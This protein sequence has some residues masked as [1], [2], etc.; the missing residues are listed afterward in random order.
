[1]AS[2]G[3]QDYTNF[4]AVNLRGSTVL[5]LQGSGGSGTFLV[6]HLE[7]DRAWSFPDKSGRFAVAGTF[8]VQLPSATAVFF[9]TIVTVTGIRAEDGLVVINNNPAAYQ[10]GTTAYILQG[11]TPGAG[12]VTLWFHNLGNATAYVEKV[13]SY[14]AVR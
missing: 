1:M 11:A 5:R 3:G 2:I 10:T 7:A 9:S 4:R 8:T 6:D 14:A 13:F 12:N